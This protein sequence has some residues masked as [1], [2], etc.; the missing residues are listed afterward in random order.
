[1]PSYLTTRTERTVAERMAVDYLE[2]GAS[3]R[4]LMF[5]EG[6]SYGAVHRLLTK[7]AGV[8]MRRRGAQDNHPG[9]RSEFEDLDHDRREELAAECAAAFAQG[10]RITG[11]A[12]QN[13]LHPWTVLRLL[14][15]AGV[16]SP[17]LLTRAPRRPR[18]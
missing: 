10:T 15:H 9:M 3:I 13:K 11:L 4:V 18:S 6:L 16:A 12:Q 5:Q 2:H 7:V 14:E 17:R 1:M 8:E